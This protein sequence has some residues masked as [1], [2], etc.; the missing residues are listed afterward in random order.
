MSDDDSDEEPNKFRISL[1]PSNRMVISDLL[2]IPGN[3]EEVEQLL[4]A[5]AKVMPIQTSLR[6]AVAFMLIASSSM[7]GRFT[8]ASTIR[9]KAGPDESGRDLLGPSLGKTLKSLEGLGLIHITSSEYDRRAAEIGLTSK[10]MDL[11][12]AALDKIADNH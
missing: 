8:T 2:P 9:Q 5:L 4:I 3:V 12:T 10:G 6:Q 11:V 7:R 1:D